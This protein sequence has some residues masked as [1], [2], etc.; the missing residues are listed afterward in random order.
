MVVPI[1]LSEYIRGKLP[2]S[3]YH[4]FETGGHFRIP[5]FLELEGE[6]IG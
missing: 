6:I 3:E 2:G 5:E 4:I 1:E